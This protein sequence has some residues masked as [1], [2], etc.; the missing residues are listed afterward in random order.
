MRSV[1]FLPFFS[2]IFVFSQGLSNQIMGKQKARERKK[3]NDP[4]NKMAGYDIH[5]PALSDELREV[6][7]AS[8]P[9]YI[10]LFHP[11]K[12][13][14]DF[15]P[16]VFEDLPLS[17]DS[18]QNIYY[19][20]S[21]KGPGKNECGGYIV[22]ADLLSYMTKTMDPGSIDTGVA[23]ILLKKLGFE[24]KDLLIETE[25][26]LEA[27]KPSARKYIERLKF[28]LNWNTGLALKEARTPSLRSLFFIKEN[29]LFRLAFFLTA[30]A[31][32]IIL[33]ILSLDA[34][35]SGDDEK[36]YE[37]AIKV[38]KYFAD[39]DPA[40][41]T[42][43]KYKLNYYGQS[44]D[45]FT[46]LLI[47]LFNLEDT[48]FEARHFVVALFGAAAILVTGLLARLLGGYGAGLLAMILMFLSPR[49]LGH[50]FN[51]P[52]DIPFLLGNVF[53]LY[54]LV[55]F[56]KKLPKISILSAVWIALGI[57]L[58]VG[59]RIGGLLL[60]P[61]IFMFSG[62][63]LMLQKWPWKMFSSGW[64]IFA[65]KGLLTLVLISLS[66]YLLSLLTWPYALQDIVN[67]PILSFKVMTNIQVSIKVLYDGMVH[68][69]DKLP[70]HYIPQ[71]ILYT[72]PTI[73]LVGTLASLFTWF[74][75]RREKMGFWYF[76][77]WFT[78]IFP[79]IFII[80]RKSNVYGGWR[81]MMFIYPS[82]IALAALSL[83]K[84]A[85]LGPKLLRLGIPVI[86][87]AGL[88]H[89]GI[90]IVKN[91]PNTYIYFNELLGGV[92]KAYGRFETDYYS[93]SLKPACDYFIEEILPEKR[94]GKGD[95]L[96]VLSN[97][98]I[99]YYFRQHKDDVVPAYSSYYRRG[100]KDWDYAIL[101][102]NYIHPYQLKKGLW[103]PKNTIHEIKVDDVVVAA[104]VE[105]R[106]WNDYMGKSLM[107][108]AMAEQDERKVIQAVMHL[109]R[110]AF[111]DPF[112]EV[113]LL[114]LAE[115]YSA[116]LEY[117]RARLTMD[118]LL[119]FY[120]DYDKALNMKGHTYLVE[121]LATDDMQCLDDAIY[122]FKQGV[123]SNNKFHIGYYNLGVCYAYRGDKNNA[124][125]NL[126]EAIRNDG[127]LYKAYEKLAEVY[128]Q[129]GEKES[130]ERV[131]NQLRRIR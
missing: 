42:S 50:A 32:F 23:E 21:F 120:P 55:I 27:E 8:S 18:R 62:L 54:H 61:Y 74:I 12:L 90:H 89:P 46:Y 108:E 25:S 111:Y 104:I 119:T 10:V 123:K 7:L 91:H 24:R 51:N 57:A 92:N 48:P 101:Y 26:P 17:P 39:D 43:P 60:V 88:L 109:E 49:F 86:I 20:F 31:I 16:G 28:K 63:Y 66:G 96:T 83:S 69:S 78:I 35:L 65:L 129:F 100:R 59:Q 68:W 95:A 114:D 113:A 71:N 38:Y 5:I 36:H 30:L 2:R 112:N 130:A 58:T 110:A 85:N 128:L 77:L 73:V 19:P 1:I 75:Q 105:R 52:L 122:W 107:K 64:W 82:M 9:G 127:K 13:S 29:S 124:I 106:D 93:S 37:H 6:D 87:L 80:Y 67:H 72:V 131:Y 94:G 99:S 41:L 76:M 11:G 40:A 98:D 117:T 44:F 53:T 22:P 47:R 70:W 125:Y 14:E 56:L 126:K 97:T 84:L 79:V 33:P 81:H 115:G 116:M 118:E 102:C 121:Y 103:P 4:D 34:G 3:H 45:F 15:D